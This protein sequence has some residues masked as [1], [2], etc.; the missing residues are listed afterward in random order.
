M[1]SAKVDEA[2]K[3]LL[4]K[5]DVG[6]LLDIGTGTGS[7][8]ELV[9]DSVSGAVGIDLSRE[10]LSVARAALD[11][12]DLRNCQVRQADMYQLPFTADRFDA[13]TMHMV[14]HY[15]ENPERAISEAARVL[16]PGGCLVIVD[17]APHNMTSLSEDMRIAGLASPMARS[18]AGSAAPV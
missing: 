14:L 12:G 6:E 9:G 3:S 15:A 2:L 1:D 4:A 16:R 13:A 17:F 7:I 8:L 18:G 11:R 10:M 5:G